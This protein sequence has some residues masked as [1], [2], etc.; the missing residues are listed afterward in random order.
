MAEA[1]TTTQDLAANQE[2]PFF[3]R[4][5]FLLPAMILLVCAVM[6]MTQP[7]R[8]SQ[9]LASTVSGADAVAIILPTPATINPRREAPDEAI[10][11][12]TIEGR[13]AVEEMISLL[14]FEFTMP[15]IA[16]RCF[17]D[18][19]FDFRQNDKKL[20][21]ITYH[22]NE[23]LRWWNGRWSGDAKL[24]SASRE[25]LSQWIEESGAEQLEQARKKAN[26]VWDEWK[27]SR[28]TDETE[29]QPS[30]SATSRQAD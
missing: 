11:G 1:N 27:K 6:A 15:W 18:I 26:A 25:A 8:R 16:C 12:L 22:H 29:T 7:H 14:E 9:Q 10:I 28:M 4:K 5:R 23:H 20:A 24:T 30:E 17:G 3:R 13:E 19:R 21:T 2:K